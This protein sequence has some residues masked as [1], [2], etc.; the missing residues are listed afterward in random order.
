MNRIFD[1]EG[2]T[3][4]AGS[5]AVLSPDGSVSFGAGSYVYNVNEIGQIVWA[6]D[7]GE[8]G[9]LQSQPR[10]PLRRMARL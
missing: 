4:A 9:M 10:L 6:F 1:I 2:P 5:A 7:T 8:G 3:E